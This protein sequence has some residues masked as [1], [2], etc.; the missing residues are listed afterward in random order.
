MGQDAFCLEASWTRM[1]RALRN[2]GTSGI[3]AMAVSAVDTALWDL[4]AR[5]LGL[6]LTDLLGPARDQPARR[7]EEQPLL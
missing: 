3:A 1:L 2:R 4:K 7:A 6:S 5:L